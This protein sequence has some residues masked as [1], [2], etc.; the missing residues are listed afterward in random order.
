MKNLLCFALLLICSA[1]LYSKEFNLSCP[2]DKDLT[3]EIYVAESPEATTGFT[4]ILNA[5][6]DKT[7]YPYAEYSRGMRMNVYPTKDEFRFVFFK[8]VHYVD[9][10]ISRKTLVASGIYRKTEKKFG[11]RKKHKLENSQCSIIKETE[12]LI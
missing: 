2:I 4:S 9:I 8:T 1:E 12:N 3:F 5:V 7:L 11:N 6:S 10:T